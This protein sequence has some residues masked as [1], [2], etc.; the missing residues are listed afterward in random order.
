MMQMISHSPFYVWPL[1]CL[2]L[3]GGWQS[4]KIYVISWKSLFIMP[5]IMFIWSIYA[6][7]ARYGNISICW[8]AISI[9]IGIWLGS[10]TVRKLQLR[11]DKQSSLI[12]VA[13]SWIPMILSLSIFCLRYFLGVAY[14]LHLDLVK[15]PA[16]LFILDNV[17]TIISGMFMGRLVGYWQ[18]SKTAP[19]IALS[20]VNT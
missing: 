18:Q 17:A 13:G 5:V 7:I 4:R 12:E 20:Q 11:F 15:N 19:H 14:G 6:T 16:L 3:W 1:F 9:A 10:L 2:L 8:W